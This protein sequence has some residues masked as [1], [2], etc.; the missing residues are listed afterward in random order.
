MTAVLQKQ[1]KKK[2]VKN[3]LGRPEEEKDTQLK[4]REKVI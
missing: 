4:S 3:I 1:E 2:K